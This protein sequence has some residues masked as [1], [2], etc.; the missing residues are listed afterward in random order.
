MHKPK[1]NAPNVTKFVVRHV[2]T[3]VVASTV[4]KVLIDN[5]PQSEKLNGAA[6]AG[7]IAGWYIGEKLEPYTDA[8][9]DTA[10]A[11]LKERKNKKT[12][13]TN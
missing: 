2:V 8:M 9:V 3:A 11:T 12:Q 5:V 13:T 7:G 4:K 1:F 6:L 10:F